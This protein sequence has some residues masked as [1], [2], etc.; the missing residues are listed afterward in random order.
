MGA[1]L[2]LLEQE[3]D[4]VRQSPQLEVEEELPIQIRMFPVAESEVAVITITQVGSQVLTTHGAPVPEGMIGRVDL[5]AAQRVP[6]EMEEQ[7]LLL[8]EAP[9]VAESQERP[10]VPQLR[11][12]LD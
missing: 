6:A 3:L 2:R 4:S 7:V 5:E 12:S 9:E 1:G 11:F 10:L 8:L